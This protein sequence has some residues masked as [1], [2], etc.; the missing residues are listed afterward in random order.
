MTDQ[1]KTLALSPA[2]RWMFLEFAHQKDQKIPDGQEGR[3]YRRWTRA[4]GI[5]HVA[6]ILREYGKIKSSAAA[7]EYDRE[8]FELT[9]ENVDYFAKLLTGPRPPLLEDVCGDVLDL[10]EDLRAGRREGPSFP[11]YPVF[12]IEADRLRWI[13]EPEE[14]SG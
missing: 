7:N 13:P 5:E 6:K 1:V 12:D 9:A 10:I 11:E 3:R 14:E 2:Q 4:I 8:I